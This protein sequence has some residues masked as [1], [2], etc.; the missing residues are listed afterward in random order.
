MSKVRIGHLD[1]TIREMNHISAK[2]NFG[3]YV[4]EAEEIHICS[5]LTPSRHAEIMI[6]EILHGIVDMQSLQFVLKDSEEH[7]VRS[8]AMG[9]A[10]TIRKNQKL[11]AHL[12]KCLR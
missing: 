10:D 3:L 5:D 9:L 6:H 8:M 11:F 4:P 2:D 12:M 7:V 1:F